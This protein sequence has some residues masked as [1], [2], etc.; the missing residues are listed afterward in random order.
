MKRLP[1]KIFKKIPD[2]FYHL[3]HKVLICSDDEKL[4]I[5]RINLLKKIHKGHNDLNICNGRRDGVSGCRD[6]C[7]KHFEKMSDYNICVKNCMNY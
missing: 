4:V 6:C 3:R 2:N 1:K 7:D 5:E